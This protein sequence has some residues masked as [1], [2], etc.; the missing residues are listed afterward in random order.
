MKSRSPNLVASLTRREA[1]I[2]VRQTN[3]PDETLV[4]RRP[5]RFE[6]AVYVHRTFA[7]RMADDR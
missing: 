2:A 1:D 5:S 3:S 4:G 6:Q 7:D